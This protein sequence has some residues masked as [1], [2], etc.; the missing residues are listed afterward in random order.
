MS[1]KSSKKRIKL[2]PVVEP[3][4]VTTSTHVTVRP[5]TTSMPPDS[6]FQKE[7]TK[8]VNVKFIL[9]EP[10]EHHVVLS[11]DFNGWATDT[12]F[13][14]RNTEGIWEIPIVLPPGRYQ[15]KF[16]VDGHWI[17]DPLSPENVWNRHGTLNSVIEVKV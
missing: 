6:E 14:N 2:L 3:A 16:V 11:G 5:T 9:L 8:M 12:M 13:M 17:P 15:Y 4:K 1:V 10:G 7:V